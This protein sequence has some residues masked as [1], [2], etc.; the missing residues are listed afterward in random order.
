MNRENFKTEPLFLG[1]S[2]TAGN[3]EKGTVHQK[4]YSREEIAALLDVVNKIPC[5]VLSK[6]MLQSV[7]RRLKQALQGVFPLSDS[8]PGEPC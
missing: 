5:S 2:D 8:E 4:T 6:R 3:I 7:N 1:F